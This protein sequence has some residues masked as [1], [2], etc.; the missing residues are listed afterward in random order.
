MAIGTGTALILS[1]L[2]GAAAKGIGDH[3][4]AQET[5]R[6]HAEAQGLD[7]RNFAETQR[8]NRFSRSMQRKQ[9]G[10]QEDRLDLQRDQFGLQQDRFG[11]EK[12]MSKY[13][14]M[15]DSIAKIENLLN[16]NVGLQNMVLGRWGS[17]GRR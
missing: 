4:N 9:F 15:Q 7:K 14:I 3:M 12:G 16:T 6:L 1:A 10:L 17:V 2:I 11:L 13:K 8:N 5:D